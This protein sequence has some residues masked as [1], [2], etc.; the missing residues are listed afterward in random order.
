MVSGPI[1]LVLLVIA[2]VLIIFGT[3]KL[4]MNAFVVLIGVA[5][6][7][8]I[9][10]RMPLE[11]VVSRVTGGFGG[12][13]GAIGI[14]IICGTII[15]TILERTGAAISI[16]QAILDLVGEKRA[17]LAMSF[18]GFVVSIPVFCDSGY[19]I[20]TPLNKALSVQAK[21]S[22]AMM[23]VA[24]GTG[25]HATHALVPPTPG[26]I[27]AAAELNADLGAVIFFGLLA[28]LVSMF[29]G[30]I[31]AIKVAGKYD[32]GME[33][34]ESYD[35]LKAK[36]GDLPGT[37]HSLLPLLIPI[38]LIVL[39]SVAA[40][41]GAPFGD[42]GFYSLT[43]FLGA[44]ATALIIG[45]LISLTL[46]PAKAKAEARSTWMGDGVKHAALIL[47]ITG[48]GGA[49]GRILQGSPM[50]AFIAETMEGLPLGLFLPFAIAVAL[51]IAQGSGTVS[52]ITTAAIM[53]PLVPVFG[54]NPVLTVLAIG[55][56]AVVV[57]HAN[58]SYFWVVTQFA[59]M[60]ASMGYKLWTVSTGVQGIASFLFVL[61][62]SI[63]M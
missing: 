39:S 61:I 33:L 49:F 10:V 26:P 34:E 18:A 29:A 6:L 57:S 46:V 63:F 30:Y 58:D 36:Y 21:K 25:L 17:P 47:A 40:F 28:A 43:R 50:V 4:Q 32:L 9:A 59:G 42:G 16:T 37:F 1:A 24:L 60:P 44:P 14:V 27:A 62:L 48:A 45:V 35:D 19:V 13:L 31:F 55:S 11:E 2:V 15:G 23:A 3:A 51:K 52:I 22:M 54:L 53:A 7:Y 38:V 12:T 8:G 41:P 56:G 5:F 20:L